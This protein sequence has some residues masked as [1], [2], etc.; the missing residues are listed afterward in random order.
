M[1]DSWKEQVPAA[2]LQYLDWH[3]NLYGFVGM[4][5]FT[6]Y[7]IVRPGSCRSIRDRKRSRLSAGMAIMI[8]RFFSSSFE[9]PMCAAGASCTIMI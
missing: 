1:L 7:P 3:K 2:L 5:D 6:L 8:A 4:K 9:I